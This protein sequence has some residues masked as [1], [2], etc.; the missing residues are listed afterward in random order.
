MSCN[1]GCDE[2]R[3]IHVYAEGTLS[4][5]ECLILP[6]G[7]RLDWTIDFSDLLGSDC[8]DASDVHTIDQSNSTATITRICG[9]VTPLAT[10]SNVDFKDADKM[11]IWVDAQTAVENQ[12]YQLDVTMTSNEGRV[13]RLCVQIQTGKVTCS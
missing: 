8:A 1:Y 6:I 10:I 11:V 5:C 9:P 2:S 12:Y 4:D 13:F 3:T 7:S